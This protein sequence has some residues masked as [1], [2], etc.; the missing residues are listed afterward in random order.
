MTQI[1]Y[2]QLLIS[3]TG[4]KNA[5]KRAGV[6]TEKMSFCGHAEYIVS[7][8]YLLDISRKWGL[9]RSRVQEKAGNWRH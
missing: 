9:V 8:P 5:W 7:T 2:S 1:F 6:G 4:I 3:F